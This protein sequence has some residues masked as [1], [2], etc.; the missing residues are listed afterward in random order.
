MVRSM[1]L[2]SDEARSLGVEIAEQGAAQLQV[3]LDHIKDVVITAERRR[4]HRPR[5]PDE[6]ARVR[7]SAGGVVRAAHRPAGSGA[8]ARNQQG[9]L[10]RRGSR[11]AGRVRRYAARQARLAR[12][13]RAPRR[14]HVV[15]GRNLH[16]PRAPRPQ[17]SVRDLPARHLRAARHRGGACATARRATA[18]WSTTRPRPSPSSTPTPRRFVEANEPALR[19]F[20]MTR[21]QLLT[22]NLGA[23][24]AEIQADGQP[25]SS[26]HRQQLAL[27]VAGES[28]VFEWIHRDS[29]GRDIPCEVRLV[30]L[31]G[32]PQAAGARQHHRHLR[33]QARR[34]HHGE[35]AR[36][37]RAA[38][39][40]RRPA[41]GA[42]RHLGAGAGRLSALPLHDLGAC[43]P[44]PAASR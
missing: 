39:L 1:Q 31:R 12:G 29:T 3:I 28:Q 19:L 7:L 15:P 32:R 36:V 10:D 11:P 9:R 22:S 33:A 13:D 25:A 16:Q 27:A 6:R 2:M 37:L 26:P 24:S 17:R 8:R 23:V 30:R 38:R 18:R 5:Q 34:D 44:T 42:R 35:R 21:D 4:H 40:Q 41:R 43:R 14:R 20:K